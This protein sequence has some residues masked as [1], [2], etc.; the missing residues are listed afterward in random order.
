MYEFLHTLPPQNVPSAEALR[1]A[2][3]REVRDR[4]Q[5]LRLS[6]EAWD[7]NR[8]GA[9]EL[10][11]FLDGLPLEEARDVRPHAASD[12]GVHD[13]FFYIKRVD[14][15]RSAIFLRSLVWT[16]RLLLLDIEESPFQICTDQLDLVDRALAAIQAWTLGVTHAPARRVAIW[17]SAGGPYRSMRRWI[18]GHQIFSALTQGLLAA[19]GE[20]RGALSRGDGPSADVA[21]D[22]IVVLLRGAGA[23][24]RFTGDMPSD[25]YLNIIRP[26]MAPPLVPETFSGVLSSDHRWFLRVLREMKPALDSLRAQRPEHHASIAQAVA[27]VYDSHKFVCDRLV[28]K[29][30]S[31]MMSSS[32]NNASGAEQIEHFKK[33]R[34]RVFEQGH[35]SPA[36]REETNSIHA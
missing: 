9:L 29:S 2:F 27:G 35:D 30:P 26:S 21:V 17:K 31:L 20:L 3:S 13:G 19:L 1:F 16:N 32:D 8:T 23:S 18:R 5:A 14:G 36:P 25:D 11:D 7:S 33:L 34:M 24:L 12:D 10:R 28:G 22:L 4:S 6:G 15:V